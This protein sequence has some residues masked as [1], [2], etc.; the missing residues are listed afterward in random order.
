MKH[1]TKKPITQILF[2]GSWWALFTMFVWELVE[3][4]LESL[5][6]FCVSEVFAIFLVKA[7]SALAIIG[8]T[9]GIK[10]CIK[11]FLVPIVKTLT[12]K[13][14]HDKMNKFKKFFT[15]VWCNKKTLVATVSTAVAGLSATDII[16]VSQ[17]PELLV[18]GYNVTPIVYYAALAVLS[19]LGVFGVG[20]ENIEDFFT[21]MCL[22]KEHKEE[23]A[24]LKEAKKEIATEEKLANQTQAEQEKARLKAE[25]E[26][27]A[28]TARQIADAEHRAKIE[29]A[30][31]TL[32]AEKN[33]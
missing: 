16:P 4:S 24:I 2:S 29:A 21:R 28:E 6:A 27:K 33:K 22:I 1:R 23:K 25:A 20:I 31:K 10:V 14:G 8:M 7:L 17:L 32:M 15:W 18:C 26:Q 9:Q 3:E 13:E 19:L 12:Y 30:K 5:I 11:R